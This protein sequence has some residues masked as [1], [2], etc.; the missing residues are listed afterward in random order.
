[1]ARETIADHIPWDDVN[2]LEDIKAEKQDDNLKLY[3]M[4]Y[5][6]EQAE[7]LLLEISVK[8]LSDSGD[9]SNF[10]TNIIEEYFNKKKE[11]Q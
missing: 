11:M 10:P 6:L 9:R 7:E 5:W 2:E 1:M 8:G 4:Q 3:E